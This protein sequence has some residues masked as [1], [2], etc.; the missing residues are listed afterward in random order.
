MK[1]CWKLERL[2]EAP[3]LSHRDRTVTFLTIVANFFKTLRPVH[4]LPQAAA[5]RPHEVPRST[6]MKLLGI[7]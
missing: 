5:R 3:R 1:F 7:P 6:Q 2:L 4:T